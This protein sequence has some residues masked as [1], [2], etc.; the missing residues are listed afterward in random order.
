VVV[1][2]DAWSAGLQRFVV[3]ARVQSGIPDY[4]S[5][6]EAFCD[7]VLGIDMWEKQREIARS[8][9][10]NRRTSVA[11][12]HAAGKT[13]TMAGVALGFL[14]TRHN[15]LVVTTAPTGDQVRNI[16]W[17]DIRKLARASRGQ[18]L[19]RALT[20]RYEIGPDWY[21]IGLSPREGGSD[22]DESN[23][24]FQGYHAA[25]I[26]I[27]IDEGAGVSEDRIE[28]LDAA[29]TS[30]RA[31]MVI[32][33]NPTSVGGTF[34]AS[35]HK[36]RTLWHNIR[37]TAFDTPNFTEGRIVRPYLIT[38]EWVR[39]AVQKY[40]EDSPYVQARVY[41]RFPTTG[42][43]TL[44]P[45]AWAEAA[46][47]REHEQPAETARWIA[48]VDVAR[49]GDDSTAIAV[50]HGR[51]LKHLFRWGNQGIT[52]SAGQIKNILHGFPDMDEVRI[53]TIGVG[54][55]LADILREDGFN[56]VDVNV[57]SQSSDPEQWPNLRHE[58]WWQM[59]ERFDVRDA[60]IFGANKLSDDALAQLSSVRY[61]FDSKHTGALVEKKEETKKRL[62]ESPDLADA[63]V[64]CF[65]TLPRTGPA[66]SRPRAQR[67]AATAR[68]NPLEHQASIASGGRRR[69]RR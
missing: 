68:T 7:D 60:R 59:R 64:I 19:G 63:L 47:A 28:A 21:A 54:G 4:P 31:R 58:I 27:I 33:G 62:K 39:E 32:V 18:L 67:M 37:I 65:A 55:G 20:T 50:R 15:S 17:R 45:L 13:F 26:L 16:L 29:M 56:V 5:T 24:T 40:G 10:F 49:F 6:I 61:G 9:E 69:R 23:T 25:D 1:E 46:N 14:H 41:A 48:G 36:D 22:T 44:I 2:T 8:V 53:D 52:Y 35:F 57:S 43:N 34:H 51:N 3:S 38:P 30:E 42:T 66:S 12:C 11:S